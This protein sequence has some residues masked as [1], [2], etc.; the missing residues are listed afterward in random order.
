M[1]ATKL[2]TCNT[3]LDVEETYEGRWVA[4]CRN[5]YDGTDDA[6]DIEHVIG[7][8][9]SFAAAVTDWREKL[10]LALDH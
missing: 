5:C 10:E 7:E 8:G 3:P 4:V 9:W 6:A 2:C 1:R